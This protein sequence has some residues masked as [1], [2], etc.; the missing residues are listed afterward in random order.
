MKEALVDVPVRVNIW[1]RSDCQKKQFEVLKKARPSI[2]FL[3]SDGGRNAKE[4]EIIHENRKL[5][6]EGIDWKCQVFKLYETENNG[7][8]KM[9]EKTRNLIWENVDRCIFLEDD[10]VPAVSYFRFCAEML[11]R[12]KD[13][14]RVSF[15]TGY[16][17]MGINKNVDSDYFFSGEG[18]IWGCATWKRTDELCNLN[19]KDS[20]YTTQKICEVARLEKKGYEK[21]ITGYANDNKYGGHVAGTEF[22][23]NFLRFA[24]GQICIVPK[25]NLIKNIGVG[26]GAAHSSDN[27]YKLPKRVQKFFNS[28]TYELD[29]P[30]THPKFCVRNIEYDNYVN[31]VLAWHHPLIF[32]CRKVETALRCLMYGDFKKIKSGVTHLFI[33]RKEK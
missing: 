9:A 22:Y 24:Q 32:T 26:E 23:K 21:I 15:V 10:Y 2:I 18:T 19:Y 12:Y 31:K 16:N 17:H 13:D 29:F 27:I 28:Q 20:L 8:Y 7:L 4:W 3:Q 25:K 30:L 6:D 14:L 1:I 11:E 5:F 33:N